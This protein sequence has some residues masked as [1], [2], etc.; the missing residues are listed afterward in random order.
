MVRNMPPALRHA[1][2]HVVA[3]LQDSAHSCLDEVQTIKVPPPLLFCQT[4]ASREQ[5]CVNSFAVV[6]FFLIQDQ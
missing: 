5:R 3:I 2:R 1:L 6:F 4:P